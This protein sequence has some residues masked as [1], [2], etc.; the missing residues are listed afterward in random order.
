MQYK[1]L[2]T[3]D[4]NKCGVGDCKRLTQ[5]AF[6]VV[7]PTTYP[8]FKFDESDCQNFIERTKMKSSVFEL[9]M[10]KCPQ[11]VVETLKMVSL[12]VVHAH[13]YPYFDLVDD[14]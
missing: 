11:V 14:K 13:K 6:Q 7:H 3:P 4:C 2:K 8:K 1:T 5:G 10:I 12:R 9:L